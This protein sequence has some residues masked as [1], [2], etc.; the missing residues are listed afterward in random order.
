LIL[1]STCVIL[2]DEMRIV[3]LDFGEKGQELL[4]DEID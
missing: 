2:C 1:G 3:G 4:S